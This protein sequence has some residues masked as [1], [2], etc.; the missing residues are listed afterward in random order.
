[1]T[2]GKETLTNTGKTWLEVQTSMSHS[3][4]PIV[5]SHFR[6]RVPT[7]ARSQQGVLD[8]QALDQEILGC[9]APMISLLRRG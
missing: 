9:R 7:E 1:M 8:L 3:T 2:I 5:C 4:E 6:A